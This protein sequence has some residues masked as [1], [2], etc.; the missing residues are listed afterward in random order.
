[1]A[2]T[3]EL[4]SA[5]YRR[6]PETAGKWAN[7]VEFQQ[8]DF[9]AAACWASLTY[10][11]HGHEIK[12]SRSDWLRELK[13]P[14]KARLSKMRCDFWW[15]VAPKGV[16]EEEELPN[17]WGFLEWNGHNFWKVRDA[18]RLRQ[19]CPKRYDDPLRLERESF[20]MLARRFAY[21]QADRD[22]LLAAVADPTPYLDVAAMATGRATASMRDGQSEWQKRMREVNKR[23]RDRTHG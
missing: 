1:M 19:V 22:S 21:A 8:I 20:A 7:I 12:A 6:Y 5:L 18:P 4:I 11:V 15:L 14:H 2:T 23:H 17:G 13:Q 16:A 10:A 9:L 3:Q